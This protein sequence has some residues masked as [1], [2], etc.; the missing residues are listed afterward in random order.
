MA[1][2]IVR[3]VAWLELHDPDGRIEITELTEEGRHEAIFQAKR[4]IEAIEA[5]DEDDG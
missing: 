5:V 4:L 1:K 2:T 3:G